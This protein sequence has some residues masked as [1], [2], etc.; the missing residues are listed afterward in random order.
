MAVKYRGPLSPD[1]R[2]LDFG[3]GWGRTL[4]FFMRDV[5]RGNLYGVDCM[6]LAIE[7]CRET[8]P[9]SRFAL[10]PPL[11]PADLPSSH[12]DL[13]YL[14][15]VF[16][17][18]SED[19]QDQWLTEF[20]RV[21]RPGGVLIATTWPREYIERCE[22]A[23]HGD[24]RGTHPGSIPAFIGTA[25]WLARYDNDEYCHSAVGGGPALPSTFYGETCIP[26]GYVR[27][28][29][30]DRFVFREFISDA[31]RCLQSVIVVQKPG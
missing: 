1:S 26:E 3:C 7:L 31:N 30:R 12:F 8:N 25:E 24:T 15:S 11:P 5:R 2:V 6:P 20:S 4:R 28:R 9:W 23:R 10:I 19:A 16:S 14:Y 22:R 29:W 17:H 13:V 21:L 18:L 27:R